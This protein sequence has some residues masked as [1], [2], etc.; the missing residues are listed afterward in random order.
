MFIRSFYWLVKALP[1]KSRKKGAAVALFLNLSAFALLLWAL[2]LAT[3]R[4]S[5][6]PL[7]ALAAMGIMFWMG[8]VRGTS[9]IVRGEA[10]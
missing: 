8:V 2:S 9:S 1:G 6:A 4:D 5:F 7:P 10:A 3:L